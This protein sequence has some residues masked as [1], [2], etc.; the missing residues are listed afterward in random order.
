[1]GNLTKSKERVRKHAEVFTPI[2]IVRQM[3]DLVENE[4]SCV[5][6]WEL[7]KTWM[8]PACG[9]G[10]FVGEIVRRKL[11][12]CESIGQGIDALKDVYAVDIQSDNVQQA[13]CQALGQFAVWCLYAG[14]DVT[15]E[16][17]HSASEII[18]R[19]IIGGDFLKPE[20]VVIYDWKACRET[21]LSDCM[22]DA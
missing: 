9:N 7:G 5:D 21:R 20:T 1:M 11:S 16:T 18:E 2:R 6:V 4:E 17:L 8:E 12:R 19:N 3:I 13:R 10:V 14:F 22:D 15:R